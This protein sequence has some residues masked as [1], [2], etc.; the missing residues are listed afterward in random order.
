MELPKRSQKL[1]WNLN[2][3]LNLVTLIGMIGGGGYLWANTT[4]DIDDLKAFVVRT[5]ERLKTLEGEARKIDG[6]TFR[7][8]V[9]ERST[10]DTVTAIKELQTLIS[11]LS[12]DLRVSREIL[13]RIE[14]A[15][16]N[17]GR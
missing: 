6:I 10:S 11:E 16:R 12:G 4:R 3:L 9:N 7:L 5:D 2:T 13:Q 14:A 8:G 17:P 1:E 15:Q